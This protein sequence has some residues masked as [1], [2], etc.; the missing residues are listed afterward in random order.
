M[1]FRKAVFVVTYSGDEYLIL[2]RKR[3]WI[4]WEFPKGGVKKFE[5]I[6]K[7]I[8]RELK[9]ETGLEII[10]ETINN[11]KHKGKFLYKKSENFNHDGQK[12]RLYSVKVKKKKTNL[13]NNPDREHSSAK[14][15]SYE[16]AMKMLTWPNQKKCL[17]IVDK[18][19]K[20]KA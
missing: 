17:K 9:E 13:K 11:H 16:K 12:Y 20:A 1:K 10:K 7:T 19:L 14:W 2:K 18:W 15:V 4:G 6:K 8:K 5:T 3:H